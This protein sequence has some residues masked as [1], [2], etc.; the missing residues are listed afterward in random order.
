MLYT[1]AQSERHGI[2]FGC[3]A[4]LEQRRE[5]RARVDHQTAVAGAYVEVEAYGIHVYVARLGG[6]VLSD[7]VARMVVPA[8]FNRRTYCR[9]HIS[10]AGALLPL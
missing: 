2:A 6:L 1:Y 9:E 8:Q 3:N 7:E 10:A 5:S 4:G